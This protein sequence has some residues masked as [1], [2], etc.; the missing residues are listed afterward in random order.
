MTVSMRLFCATLATA[1]FPVSLGCS[2]SLDSR[3]ASPPG[4][5]ARRS[6]PLFVNGGFESGDLS[7]WTL[8]TFIN[9]GIGIFPPSSAADLNLASGGTTRTYARNGA[10]ESQVPAGLSSSSSLRYPRY[11]NWAGIVN[12]LGNQQNVN[13]LWQSH[14]TTAAD[15]DPT[16]GNV[17]LRFVIAPVLQ[18]PGHGNSQQPYFFV[19]VTNVTKSLVLFSTFNFSNQ[20]GVP[21]LTDTNGNVYTNWQIVDVAP[22]TTGLVIGDTV[23]VEI[24]SAGCSLGGHYGHVYVDAFGASLPGLGIAG[25][26]PQSANS[27]SNITYIY[28]VT[29]GGTAAADGVVMTSTLPLNTTFVSLTAPAGVSCTLPPVGSAG[30]ASCNLSTLSPSDRVQISMTVKIT[31]G[32]TGQIN[33]GNYTVQGPGESPLIG[34]LVVTNITSGTT[35]ADLSI[36]KT[37]GVAAIGWG[38]AD[39]YTIVV[40][41][42]GPNNVTGAQVTDTIP[43]QLT[44]A[45]WT[46]TPG[47]G[48]NCGAASGTG[49]IN[50]TVNLNT[51]ASATFLLNAN[52]ISGTGSSSVTNTASI[53]TPAGI[54]DPDTR[55]N[56]AADV[57]RIGTLDTVTV[58]KGPT[59]PGRIVSS[60]TAID[61][62]S[63]CSSASAR[64]LDGSLVALSALANSGAA[65]MGWSGGCSG[66]VSPCSLTLSGN[67]SVGALFGYLIS[68]SVPGGNGTLVCNSPVVPGSTSI[69]TLS[70]SSGYTVDTLTDNGLSVF[71]SISGSTYSISNVSATHAMVA[72]FKKNLSTTCTVASECHSTFCADSVCCNVGCGGQC[73]ACDVVGSAG[74]CSTV[75]GAPHGSRTACT[76]DGSAC[77]GSCNGTNPTACTFPGSSTRCR[78]ASCS[79][80][81]ATLAANCSGNGSCPT[82]QTQPCTP[83]VCGPSAC[84]GNCGSDADCVG[85][86]YCSAGIC[87]PKL[88]N[89]TSCSGPNQCVS[90]ICVDNVCCNAV[91]NG[92]CQACDVISSVGACTNVTGAPH[93]G[94]TACASDG[95]SCRGTCDG[96]TPTTCSYP[97]AGTSCRSASCSS[98]TAILAASCQGTGSCPAVQTQLCSP[99]VCGPT[100]CLG[101]CSGD[102]DCVSADYCS[103]GVCTPKLGNGGRCSSPNQCGSNFCIDGV[104][105]NTA[106]NG[107]CQACDVARSVGTCSNVTGA[108]HGGR[109]LC[110]SDGTICGG[111]CDGTNAFSCAYPGSSTACRAPN[112][113]AGLATLPASCQG[114]GTCPALQTQ[115]C[116]PYVC[117]ATACLGNCSTD[118]DCISADYCSGGVCVPKLTNGTSCGGPNQCASGMCVDNYCCNAACAGECQACDVIGS[119]G[120]CVAVSGAPHGGRTPCTTDGTSCG[121]R[122]DGTTTSACTYPGASTQCRAP[123]CATGT[124]TAA[125]NCAGTGACPPVQTRACTPYI[126]GPTACGTSCLSDAECASGNYCASGTCVAK[127]SNGNTCS[128]ADQCVSGN[129]IDGRCCNSACGGQCQACDRAG[130]LGTCST[131]VGAPHGNRPACSTDGT[132]CGGSCGGVSPVTCVYPGG[133]AECRAASCTN[134]TATLPA[135]CTGTGRCPA[136]QN[137]SCGVYSCG[138]TLCLG[139]CASDDNCASGKYCSAGVCQPKQSNGSPCTAENQCASG[140]CAD[141]YCCNEA[142]GG[143]CQACNVTNSEGTCTPVSGPNPPG[144]VP[145]SPYLCGAGAC[146]TACLVDSDCTIG[147]YCYLGTCRPQAQGNVG[148]WKA[149]GSG[150]V[151]GCS[152]AAGNPIWALPLV[153]LALSLLS[154][155]RRNVVRTVTAGLPILVLLS[156]QAHADDVNLSFSVNRFQASGGAFDVLNVES[157]RV[158]QGHYFDYGVSL[159]A[160][161]ADRPLRLIATGDPRVQIPLLKSQMTLDAGLTFGFLGRYELSFVMPFTAI[162]PSGIAPMVSDRLAAP[163]ASAG[164]S[165]LRVTPKVFL[166]ETA[167]FRLAASLRTT[168]PTGRGGSYLGYGSATAVPTAIVEYAGAHGLRV[169]ANVGLELRQRR[170]FVDAYVGNAFAYGLG[171]ELPFGVNSRTLTAMATFVGEQQL[172]HKGAA[173]HPMELLGGFRL[174]PWRGLGFTLAG[175]PGLSQGYGTPS[176]RILGGLSFSPQ[177]APQMIAPNPLSPF[178]VPDLNM[179]TQSDHVSELDV[180]AAIHSTAGGEVQLVKAGSPGAGIV[181]VVDHRAVRYHPKPDFVGTDTFDYQARD[182]S[183]QLASGLV[184]VQVLAPP[185]PPTVVAKVEAAPA[186][187][188]LETERITILEP[189]R[190]ETGK[191][192]LLSESRPLLHEVATILKTHPELKKLRVEGHTDN[193]GSSAS[194]MRLSAGRAKSVRQFLVDEGIETSR[195]EEASFGPTRP[196]AS[197]AT[198]EGRA[199]NRR[200]EFIII[201]Q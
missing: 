1:L 142:C 84:L 201:E 14:Q 30:T 187:V 47:A 110:S 23:K 50:T 60:P 57:D 56:V 162:Q 119:R 128:A 6:S 2:N 19:V 61:C 112:C 168:L 28:T 102:G 129:C 68:T 86:D 137:Q 79:G 176:Y 93:G 150:G 109:T 18:N 91:C 188:V 10:T 73:Q 146:T 184:R 49:N 77:G 156:P 69:C 46:C 132:A 147:N 58:T 66:A 90:N 166:A 54:S 122:C 159:F 43:A 48:A 167:A 78:A 130:S 191:D 104:C 31:A 175:G 92:Q 181:E 21:W 16:D 200:V 148:D 89:G 139:D 32:S 95:T 97:G 172:S 22:G 96:T 121:G 189:V 125:A 174:E 143:Q 158:L 163:V 198:S 33:H 118:R 165:D 140:T 53:S 124:A 195:L 173:E 141:G 38:E 192:L 87:T 153:A 164:F 131:I 98:G 107:Q 52:V 71:G 178:S 106:C 85:A 127:K 27:D 7:G 13:L 17:H 99:Y 149:R 24:Y 45:T 9:N 25:T 116:T 123:S 3:P 81:T 182:P 194:N 100:A 42:A 183:G 82:L 161:Y 171:A 34:P 67:V 39:Q 4:N 12:E 103:G 190:F 74:T 63:G 117:G 169:A 37:D 70:P 134:G 83:Y 185:A 113:A 75:T 55:N 108:P 88:A 157:A 8:Q 36:S 126:C 76:S 151:F 135:S 40:R 11:G 193:Q 133:S 101:N 72:T 155:R 115:P 80:G 120:N 59:W 62:G 180:L 136:V 144:R 152:S 44:G 26:G 170:Q 154:R 94:R 179:I 5:V 197:N 186:K 111:S 114:T 15:V 138:T 64:F 41:N 65:F 145:C 160:N 199:R 177:Y 20:A 29:N 35:Y 196:V 51:G 105:C